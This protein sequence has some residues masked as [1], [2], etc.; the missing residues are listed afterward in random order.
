M[1]TA[2]FAPN[3]YSDIFFIDDA[4][5]T[6]FPTTTR[7]LPSVFPYLVKRN[8]NGSYDGLREPNDFKD[9][10][11]VRPKHGGYYSQVLYSRTFFI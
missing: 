11:L 10:L 9:F 3:S 6:F 5:K 4:V 7:N 2:N 8:D 1:P